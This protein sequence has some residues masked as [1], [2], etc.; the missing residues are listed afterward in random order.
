VKA[1]L[2]MA[3][4]R[5]SRQLALALGMVLAAPIPRVV[6][7]ECPAAAE[8]TR[9][10]YIQA[11]LETSVWVLWLTKEPGV[12]KVRYWTA[13]GEAALAAEAEATDRHRV[14][15]SGLAP[16][17][18]YDYEILDGDHVLLGGFRFRT[19]P[20]AGTGTV[21]LAVIGDS[22][23]T[24][25]GQFA[26]A[27]LIKEMDPDLFLHT[28]DLVYVKDMDATVFKPYCEI[29]PNACFYCARGGHNLSI[30][31]RDFF[32]P[33]MENPEETGTYYSF[34]WASAH[35]VV[36]DSDYKFDP[37]TVEQSV[38][39]QWLRSDLANA[40]ASPAKWIVLCLHEC[41]FT[42][43][44]H[45]VDDRVTRWLIP[46]IVDEFGVDIVL[47]GHDHNYQRSHPI[48]MREGAPAIVDAWQD[49]EFVSP[50]GTPYI[51]TGGGG[52][53]LY[54]CGKGP[55][56]GRDGPYIRLCEPAFHAVELEI[57]PAV[58]SVRVVDKDKKVIDSFTIR[59]DEPRP[60]FGFVRGDADMSGGLQITDPIRIL[61][62]LFLGE[63]MDCPAAAEVHGDGGA[64][65]IGD[66]VYL[67]SFLFLGTPPPAAP[68]PECGPS[69]GMDPD[70]CTRAGCRIQ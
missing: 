39:I 68:F 62:H 44:N 48:R 7:A 49:P 9:G 63:R 56:A 51:V 36:L 37:E 28:G 27:A 34:D 33:P 10:P 3:R 25:A 22:G 14:S 60:E 61:G 11:L 35:F 26:V 13:G 50:R 69:P 8:V 29:L 23:S 46:P 4:L 31:P 57:A 55:D 64:L 42:V 16:D 12:G 47:T 40:K 30:V 43:G 15:L 53:I 20:P 38:Q 19:S 5:I 70:G 58:L 66:A 59:K 41:V 67:L 65:D 2:M 6:A 52:G 18:R 21:R 32:V 54:D 24:S 17:T 45:S 1:R